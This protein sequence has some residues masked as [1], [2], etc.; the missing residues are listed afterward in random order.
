MDIACPAGGGATE[1]RLCDRRAG[2]RRGKHLLDH[3]HLSRCG[4]AR[5]LP[6]LFGGGG[7]ALAAVGRSKGERLSTVAFIV[8]G[9]G[10]VA[11]MIIGAIIGIQM[12][13]K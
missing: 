2:P 10:L 8:S 3:R 11:G 9:V 7:I 6:I 1:P 5:L 12:F 4:R 13:G